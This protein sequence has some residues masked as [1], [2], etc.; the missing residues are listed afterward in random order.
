MA[1]AV[2]KKNIDNLLKPFCMSNVSLKQINSSK[3]ITAVYFSIYPFSDEVSHGKCAMKSSDNI[4]WE[5]LK[6]S[7]NAVRW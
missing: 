2:T 7:E 1:E 4:Y 3:S 5:W 6:N